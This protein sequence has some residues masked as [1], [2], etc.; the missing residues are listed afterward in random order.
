[1]HKM[2]ISFGGG[3]IVSLLVIVILFSSEYRYIPL[4]FIIFSLYLIISLY[5]THASRWND[6][7]SIKI[8]KIHFQFNEERF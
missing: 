3:I 8:V 2:E 4:Y 6:I 7:F 5:F 1:M